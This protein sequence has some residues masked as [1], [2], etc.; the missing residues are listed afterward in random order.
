MIDLQLKLF[1]S[2]VEPILLY[3]WEVW[4]F[5]NIIDIERIHLHCKN[6]LHLRPH[7]INFLFFGHFTRKIGRVGEFF[8]FSQKLNFWKRQILSEAIDTIFLLDNV[9]WIYIIVQTASV[10][11]PRL[12]LLW[13]GCLVVYLQFK[14]NISIVLLMKWK[15]GK[16]KSSVCLLNEKYAELYGLWWT[17]TFSTNY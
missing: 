16:T 6:I 8:F 10:Q 7:Q 5:G 1:N 15:Q 9:V 14:R 3:G 4:G 12:H 2:N 11:C 13:Q 17:G